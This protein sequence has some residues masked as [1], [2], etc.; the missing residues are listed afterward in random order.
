MHLFW[1][2]PPRAAI[3]PIFDWHTPHPPPGLVPSS[4]HSSI[5]LGD[6]KCRFFV[7]TCMC[8]FV[9]T[10]SPRDGKA[11]RGRQTWAQPLGCPLSHRVSCVVSELLLGYHTSSSTQA[12]N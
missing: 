11:L 6:S 12:N 8:D 2:P 3:T 4:P 10:S 7:H 1:L 9:T 5:T